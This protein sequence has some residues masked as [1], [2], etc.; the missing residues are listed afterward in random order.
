MSG[1]RLVDPG[2]NGIKIY[3][4]DGAQVLGARDRALMA[5]IERAMAAPLPAIEQGKASR[6]T[7]LPLDE[8]DAA[9]HAFDSG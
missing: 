5:A 4:C 6:I 2:D 8:V 9:Y 1:P 3:D 7:V